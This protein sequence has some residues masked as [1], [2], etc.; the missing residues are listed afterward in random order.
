MKNLLKKELSELMNTQFLLS[1]LVTFILVAAV[2]LVMTTTLSETVS[3]SGEIHLIDNDRTEFTQKL[4]QEL[5]ADGYRVLCAQGDAYQDILSENGWS[6]AAVLPAGFTDTLLVQKQQADLESI[7]ALT[8][9]SSIQLSLHQGISTSETMEKIQELLMQE[10]LGDEEAFL[11]API[12]EV[13][14]TAANGKMAKGSSFAIVSSMTLFDQLMP[15]VLFLLVILSCQTIITAIGTEK[16]DKTL[17]TLLSSPVPRL[18]IFEAKLLA[19]LIV[20]VIYALSCGMG[21]LIPLLAG[22]S[23]TAES[24][25]I[26]SAL[27]SLA[28]TRQAVDTLELGISGWG[29]ILVLLQLILTLAITLVTSLILGALVQDA[30]GSQNASLPILLATMF[31]YLLSMV[32]DIRQMELLPRLL[33][34]CIPF[35]H[36]FIATG[37]M[38][39]H[40]YGLM[41]GGIVYQA[42][43]LSVMVFAALRVYRSDILFVHRSRRQKKQ[44]DTNS[45]SKY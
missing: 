7:T 10:A 32:S 4:V 14:Y 43:F 30:K 9:T 2:G 15:M 25:D 31:P 26:G 34:Y 41:A 12:K 1:L 37:C 24:V 6:E 13:P 18:Q 16:T 17:E 38:R 19:A 39:F 3:E 28:L 29:W 36:T 40:D 45:H 35:T 20:A 8:S 11:S 44:E 5:E 27:G 22:V 42:V 33:L 21:F 23:S